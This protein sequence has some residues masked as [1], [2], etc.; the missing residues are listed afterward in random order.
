MQPPAS[1]S[2]KC[3]SSE[4]EP[5]LTQPV[6]RAGSVLTCAKLVHHVRPQNGCTLEVS[7]D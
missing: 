3:A 5:D 4:I 6:I 2:A 1:E 7:F